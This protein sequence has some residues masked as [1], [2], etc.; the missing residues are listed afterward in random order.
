MVIENEYVR[1]LNEAGLYL[2]IHSQAGREGK[3]GH[4]D[5]R[6]AGVKRYV[7]GGTVSIQMRAGEGRRGASSL[8]I[9]SL[10]VAWLKSVPDLLQ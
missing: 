10:Q 3:C 2:F 1:Y 6:K 7:A 9:L 5:A 8:T 4:E